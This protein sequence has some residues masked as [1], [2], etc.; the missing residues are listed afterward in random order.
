[1]IT[2]RFLSA[3]TLSAAATKLRTSP[4]HCSRSLTT[5][6]NLHA[7]EILDSRGNPTVEVE[8]TS[9][10]GSVHVVMVPSGASTG[11]ME[12]TEL[13]DG[14]TR[15]GGKGVKNACTN[16]VEKILPVVKGMSTEDVAAIDGA[17]ISLDGTPNKSVLGANAI[18]AVSMATC[19][20]GAASKGAPLY[21]FLN[22]MAGSPKMVMP[23]PCFNVINGGVHAGNYL[24]PQEFFLI[25]L[26]APNSKEALRMGAETYHTLKDIIK[27][28]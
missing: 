12:A 25:P 16:V 15:Y 6:S 1:M 13:R 19:R 3:R 2:S 27:V 11:D 22:E 14:G 28:D 4:L 9:S 5:I 23:V 18:L 20:A 26:G 17:M 21:K 8:L 7:R 10:D 24:A